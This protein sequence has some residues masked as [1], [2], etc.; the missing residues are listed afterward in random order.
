MLPRGRSIS[1]RVFVMSATLCKHYIQQRTRVRGNTMQQAELQSSDYNPSAGRQPLKDHILHSESPQTDHQR[2]AESKADRRRNVG[3]RERKAS[4]AAGSLITLIGISRRSVPGALAAVAGSAL[5]YRGLI[6]YCSLYDALG[7]NTHSPESKSASL[8]E[9]EVSEA[10]SIHASPEQ[11]YS[12]WRTLEQLPRVLSHIESV[13]VTGEGRSHWVAKPLAKLN[14][15]VE[16]DAE[17]TEDEPNHR[18]AW[19]SL[20]SSSVHTRGSI[21]FQKAL[22]DRGTA[23]RVSMQYRLPGGA[24]TNL[25]AKLFGNSPKSLIRED[26]RNFKRVIETGEIPR[27]DGQPRGQCNQEKRNG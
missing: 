24:P 3:A 25:L 12:F 19:Q 9:I 5:A 6:G 2:N 8:G 13:T 26:L 15:T 16:W 4:L 1:R 18:I 27:I 14:T 10:F 17:I 7:I 22:G 20:T 23:V 11:L 21:T